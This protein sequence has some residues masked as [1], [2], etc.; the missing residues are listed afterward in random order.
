MEFKSEM[1]LL[2][3]ALPGVKFIL[4]K[5]TWI[6]FKTHYKLSNAEI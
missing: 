3:Y 5:I 4:S 6:K 1:N 2:W